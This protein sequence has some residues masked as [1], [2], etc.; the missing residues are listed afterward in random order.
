VE[1]KELRSLVALSRLGSISQSAEYLHLTPPGIHK[2]LKTM[3]ANLGVRL[4]Q[5]LGRHLQLTP[6]AEQILPYLKDILAQYDSMISVVDEWKGLKRGVVRVGC[7]PSRYL[8]PIILK[9]F[10]RQNPGIEVIVQTGNTPVLLRGLQEGTIDLAMLISPDLLES[11]DLAVEV[12][13]DFEMVLVSH[14]RPVQPHLRLSDLKHA[15]FI[16]FREGSRME[17]SID[18]YL[19]AHSFSPHVVMRFDDAEF[20]CAMVR[21]GMGISMLPIWAVHRDIKEGKLFRIRQSEPPLH[22]KIAMVRRKSG[23]LSRATGAFVN[24]A[25]SLG[26]ESAITRLEHGTQV[27]IQGL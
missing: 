27:L 4:Y 26:L 19:A 10:R 24:T 12:S 14:L 13:W 11:S 3:E 2:H 15:R 18:R 25:R 7:G 8:L 20:I 1:L 9:R 22:S 17:E 16:L 5:K 21:A 23:L 6:V